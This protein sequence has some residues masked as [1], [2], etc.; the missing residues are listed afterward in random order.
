MRFPWTK[1]PE[2]RES[3]YS[4]AVL[5][6]LQSQAEGASDIATGSTAVETAC[7]G[8]WA[9]AFAVADVQPQTPATMAL[10]A[11]VLSLMAESLFDRGQSIWSIDV[12]DGMVKLMRATDWDV[13]ESWYRVTHTTPD[14]VRTAYLRP[15]SVI[16]LKISAPIGQPW[17]GAAPVSA[18]S[19][20]TAQLM[21][22]L[23]QRLAQE[24]AGT[25]GHVCCPMP[26]VDGSTE[27]L[28]A[29]IPKL[30]GRTVMVPSTAG[31]WD[32]G[33]QRAAPRSDWQ[34]QRLGAQPPPELIRLRADVGADIAAAAGVPP[35]LLSNISDGTA[36]RESFRF[37][38]HTSVQPIAALILPELREKLD[39]PNLSIS[40]DR[41][42]AGDLSGR[43]RA[44]QS[45]VGGGMELRRRRVWPG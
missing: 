36:R 19:A 17:E 20:T 13:R 32:Q 10:T 30:K 26:T 23:E 31:N 27:K 35:A 5:A 38:L 24:V 16:D 29:D 41:L 14:N 28:Q 11:T 6:L 8:L 9:R 21:A 40:F 43:A 25:I 42:F 4:D 15:E 2:T 22:T 18:Q 12:A 37:F 33:P 3:S 45:M 39:E 7:R 44:F 34:P 1:T